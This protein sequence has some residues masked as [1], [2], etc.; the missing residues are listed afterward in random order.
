MQTNKPA[1][2]P[3]IA[4]LDDAPILSEAEAQ[5]VEEF[6][7]NAFV[8]R[9]RGR[10]PTGNAKEQVSVRLNR[11][12]LAKLRA[13]GPGWQTHVNLRLEWVDK[14]A[15]DLHRQLDLLRS[16]KMRSFEN[17]GQGDVNTTAANI[18]RIEGWLAEL[19]ITAK[20]LAKAAV[21]GL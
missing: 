15:Q 21:E 13:A 10:P 11:D 17:Y 12:V 4:D 9:G 6:E 5:E 8:R 2:F 18:E 19:D 16:G 1:G 3:E 14:R 7:G 20:I